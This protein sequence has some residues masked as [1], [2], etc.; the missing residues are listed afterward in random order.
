MTVST[1]RYL[2][3]FAATAVLGLGLYGCGGGGGGPVA[4]GDGMMPGD[5]DG[6]TPGDGDGTTTP[7]TVDL[8]SVAPGFMA[9]AGTVTIEAGQSE[10]HGDV[11]FACAAGDDD[12]TVT[13]AS[14]GTV[15]STGG[16]VTAVNA[17]AYDMRIT[18]LA[19]NE[20][21]SI[22]AATG[23]DVASGSALLFPRTTIPS[24][25]GSSYTGTYAS[26]TPSEGSREQWSRAIPW[27]DGAGEVHF[28][29]SVGSGLSAVELDP[30]D[31]MGRSIYTTDISD[32][33]E[34]TNHGL[35][36][37]WKAFDAE[38]EY[39]GAGTLT[40]T[41]A[42]D[43][44]DAGTVER[45]WVGYGDFDRT[46]ELSDIPALP[47]DRDWQGVDVAG[48]LTGSLDGVS[49]EF[50]CAS[51]ASACWLE[52][53]RDADA[54]GYYSYGDVVFT[55][56]DNGATEVLPSVTNSQTVSTADYLIFGTWQ[57]VPDDITA[58][59]DY[60]FGVFAGGG[61]PF[62]SSDAAANL[63]GT[64]T[65]NGSAQGMYYTGRSSTTPTVGSFDARVTL[66]ADFGS[67]ADTFD[68]GRLSGTVQNIR[69]DGAAPG[70]PAQLTLRGE[71]TPEAS[72][73]TLEFV[74]KHISAVG[75]VSDGQS[76]PSWSGT[77]QAAFFGN[78]AD[79]NEHPAGVAGTF[80]ASNDDDGL[81]GAFGARR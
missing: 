8:S 54:E 76:T 47:V 58:A 79:P 55:R 32:Y 43:V 64:A 33:T 52:L 23:F 9:E 6:L 34:D 62:S 51:G 71:G 69:Y 28:E 11:A 49:G 10:D 2:T 17:D 57:Y 40:V 68:Y 56:D 65:Y 21:N 3:A 48:G 12:C 78:G 60:E 27:I 67:A 53:W 80:G 14:D 13:I 16:M 46:I 74:R 30:V 25:S 22:H 59:D 35:G 31:W 7:M 39:A 36:S 66:E 41:V 73:E 42:T 24:G 37:D 61:D 77:W 70:F 19:T 15:T 75:L 63:F 45:P 50:T 5:G 81:V 26:R 1:K 72:I 44:H 18:T 38:M 20:A 4:D 29:F